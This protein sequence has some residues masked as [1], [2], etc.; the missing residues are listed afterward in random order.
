MS[1]SADP[2]DLKQKIAEERALAKQ[3]KVDKDD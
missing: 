1:K 3:I 2:L